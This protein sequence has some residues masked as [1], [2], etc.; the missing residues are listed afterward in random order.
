MKK[1]ILKYY[2]LMKEFMYTYRLVFMAENEKWKS[3]MV[4]QDFTDIEEIKKK[5]KVSWVLKG[6]PGSWL[7]GKEYPNIIWFLW[8][9]RDGD[10]IIRYET[11]E[12]YNIL[13][14]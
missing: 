12:V 5:F 2:N 11:Q 8:G 10:N 7:A 13:S 1:L 4:T 9:M 14:A 6:R 3:E